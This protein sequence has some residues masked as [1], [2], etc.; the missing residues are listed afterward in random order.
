MWANHPIRPKPRPGRRADGVEQ[1]GEHELGIGQ[2]FADFRPTQRNDVHAVV[3]RLLAARGFGQVAADLRQRVV[4]DQ[5]RA[6]RR[7]KPLIRDGYSSTTLG[8]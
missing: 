7:A 2:A 4:A 3:A 1:P 8:K 5:Q 6:C